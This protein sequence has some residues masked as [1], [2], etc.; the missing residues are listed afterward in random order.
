MTLLNLLLINFSITLGLTFA[1]WLLS[2]RLRDASIVDIFWGPGFAMHAWTTLL[3][4]PASTARA[5]LLVAMATVWGLRLGVHLAWR[6]IGRAEDARYRQLR[7]YCGPS[8]WLT[9]LFV[10][11]WLQALIMSLVAM[12]LIAG[13][14]SPAPLWWLDGVGFAIWLT[15]LTCESISDWQLA[16]FKANPANRG[17]VL[18]SGLWRYT[19]HPN[20]F[21]DF[22]VW[23]G[24]YA[25]A[26]AGGAWWTVI[27]PLLM[28]WLLMRVSGVS[29]LEKSLEAR[30]PGYA[31]Y[32]RRTSAFLPLPPKNPS[33]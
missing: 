23:W 32:Q 30:R 21:G 19:R 9:S 10:V 22:L 18:D 17:K 1:L 16:R 24:I 25:T 3:L 20:Y 12:P 28:S 29:L 7:E 5:W 31:E 4:Y 15:G 8:F 2:V 33:P 13:Q 27:S 26:A 14:L 11:F 6:N